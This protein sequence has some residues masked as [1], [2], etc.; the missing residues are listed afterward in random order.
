M[1]AVLP[2]CSSRP[3]LKYHISHKCYALPLCCAVPQKYIMLSPDEV[4]EWEAD[5][6]RWLL[7]SPPA[8]MPACQLPAPSLPA[9]LNWPAP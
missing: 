6:E 1:A 7:A 3:A 2:R 9:W 4:A 5:P 8:C